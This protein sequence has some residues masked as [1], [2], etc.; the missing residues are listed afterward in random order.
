LCQ[1]IVFFK[2]LPEALAPGDSTTVV[3]PNVVTGSVETIANVTGTPYSADGRKVLDHPV[4]FDSDAA[5]IGMIKL[6]PSVS[7]LN[8]VYLGDDDGASCG[9]KIA[10][11]EVE[12][13]FGQAV[14]YCF[15]VTN[16]GDAH[17]SSL[18]IENEKVSF[19]DTSI[20]HLAPGASATVS[21]P[22]KIAAT[23]MN[24]A[25]VTAKPVSIIAIAVPII[26]TCSSVL[27][28]S[29]MGVTLAWNP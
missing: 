4:V 13:S 23:L 11:D 2:T 17:L 9:S 10:V 14:T 15:T 19:R 6:S 27:R 12:E 3:V 8:T 22:G 25:V 16:G 24:T 5:S 29:R 26:L 1:D 20:V 28:C 21:L 7:I 18:V